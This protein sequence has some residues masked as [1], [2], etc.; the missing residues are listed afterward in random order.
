M[1]QVLSVEEIAAIE[2]RNA[3]RMPVIK[4]AK[5]GVGSGVAESVFDCLVIDESASGVLID[6][7]AVVALPEE[8]TIQFSSGATYLARRRWSVGTKA[9]LEFRG[10]Q[11]INTDAAMRMLKIA[12]ILGGQGVLAAVN[13]LRAA[14]FFDHHEL[15]RVAEEAEASY[16]RFEALLT[17]R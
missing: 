14:R 16:L 3:P 6:F 17:G 4:S 1:R 8:V 7:G 5:V 2:R 15:R 13:T 11:L 10:G 12:E 9:G